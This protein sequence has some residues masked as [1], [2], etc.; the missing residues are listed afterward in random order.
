MTQP[1]WTD[2]LTAISAA[3]IGLIGLY[4]AF[5][6]E[7][8]SQLKWKHELYDRRM[9]IYVAAGQSIGFMYRNGKLTDEALFEFLQATRES[10]FLLNEK[11]TERLQ[12][13]YK[14]AVD[15][16]TLNFELEDLPV[17][18]ERTAKVHERADIK[19]WYIDQAYELKELFTP[20]LKLST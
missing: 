15:L 7:A 12:E 4:F 16:Q 6:Q 10:D 17:G 1:S 5:R 14:R 8:M 20:F 11:I 2:V 18:E 9:A 3:G 13:M 19:V